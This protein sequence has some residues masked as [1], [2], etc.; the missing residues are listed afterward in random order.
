MLNCY[1]YYIKKE[2]AMTKYEEILAHEEA[3]QVL[4]NEIQKIKKAPKQGTVNRG[5]YII[6]T[7][8]VEWAYSKGDRMW[9][10]SV[11]NGHIHCRS[12]NP[13]YRDSG[14]FWVSNSDW[15]KDE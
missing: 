1:N 13:K 10:D 7:A 8:S 6:C 12:A 15:V 14:I 4:K 11:S 9:V 2:K 5:D 3:I